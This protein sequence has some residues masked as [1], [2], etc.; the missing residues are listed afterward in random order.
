MTK[1][2]KIAGTALV[3]SLALGLAAPAS[4]SGWN[5]GN[6]FRHQI[7]QLDRQVDRADR[8]GALSRRDASELRWHVDRL[9]RKWQQSSY[10]GFNRNE[11]ATLRQMIGNV[12]RHIA[13][14]IRDGHRLTRDDRFD[15]HDRYG[16]DY[17]YDRHDR[18]DR[19]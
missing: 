1:T 7:E 15:R 4:A 9:E 5:W 17:R 2:G 11:V 14:Q 16:P 6:Q 12:E 18:Y 10:G 19:R 3:A 8:R 13:T